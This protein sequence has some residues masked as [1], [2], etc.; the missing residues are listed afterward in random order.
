M[1][2]IFFTFVIYLLQMA[3]CCIINIFIKSRIP[4]NT[5]DFLNMTFLPL[6]LRHTH[7][8]KEKSKDRFD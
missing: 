8:V 5:S 4:I 7:D 1:I 2:I 3:I 6:L